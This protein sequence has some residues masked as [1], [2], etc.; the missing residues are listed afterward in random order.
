MNIFDEVHY[1]N[2]KNELNLQGKIVIRHAV[3]AVVFNG[4]S[5]LMAHL[6]KTGEHKFPGGGRW[7]G[8]SP[9]EALRREVM[10][11]VGYRVT[12][13]GPRI[14]TITEYDHAAEGPEYLFKMISDYYLAQVDPVPQEQALED[15]ERELL[16]R[17][18]WAGIEGM[19]QIQ[20]EIIN[21]KSPATPGIYRETIALGKIFENLP[22]EAPWMSQ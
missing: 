14:G 12:A 11:E 18:C 16:Y 15:N 13:I 1:R 22:Y 10:E 3:R 20:R 4:K 5:L 9:E 2:P 8:E 21:Q 17:P 19:L 6:G 7:E